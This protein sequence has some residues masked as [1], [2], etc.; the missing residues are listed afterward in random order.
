MAVIPI[1]IR[2][3]GRWDENKKYVDF[4]FT[5][6]LV[7]EGITYLEFVEFL[8]KEPYLGLD[9]L[10]HIIHLFVD[11]DYDGSRNNLL[12]IKSDSGLAW[13]LYMA[14]D[15]NAM[16]YPLIIT[17]DEVL[18]EDL[19]MSTASFSPIGLSLLGRG[20]S[21]DE[22]SLSFLGGDSCVVEAG[23]SSLGSG[24]C[25]LDVGSSSKCSGSTRTFEVVHLPRKLEVLLFL[26][27]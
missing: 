4:R 7:K 3:D 22:H 15:D 12:E 6:T 20:S 9:R 2:Y 24:T 8:F 13:F 27:F 26:P 23:S 11:M 1:I 5:G 17:Y 21:V 10:R 19:N 14:K 25:V 18:L 16:K